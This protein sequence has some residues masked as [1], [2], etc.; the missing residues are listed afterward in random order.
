[1]AAEHDQ[2]TEPGRVAVLDGPA[3]RRW[4]GV[5]LAA[6][7]AAREEI[8]RLNVYPVPDADTGTNLVRTMQAG[9][10]ALAAAGAGPGAD[11]LASVCE[12]LA[13]ALL[14]GAC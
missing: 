12:T 7:V 8:D 11:S 9:V 4:A 13:T 1:M 5:G 14:R 6:L 2:H 3:V 10:E